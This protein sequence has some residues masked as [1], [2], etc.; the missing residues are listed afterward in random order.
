LESQKKVL[1]VSDHRKAKNQRRRVK[2][3]A[4]S[5]QMQIQTEDDDDEYI[6]SDLDEDDDGDY[7]EDQ[8]DKE[9][10]KSMQIL[11]PISRDRIL[12]YFTSDPARLEVQQRNILKENREAWGRMKELM[13]QLGDYVKRVNLTKKFSNLIIKTSYIDCVLEICST[14]YY[15]ISKLQTILSGMSFFSIFK[16]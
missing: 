7:V 10:A 6:P 5:S 13:N 3:P 12:K 14:T 16:G 4:S 2:R 1:T 11:K 8:V 15:Q 9:M